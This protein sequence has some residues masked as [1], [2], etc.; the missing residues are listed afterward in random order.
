MPSLEWPKRHGWKLLVSNG[1]LRATGTAD[2][3][4][5]PAIAAPSAGGHHH[6]RW[7]WR[8]WQVAVWS[9]P[10]HGSAPRG[11]LD[12]ELTHAVAEG[13]GAQAKAGGGLIGTFDDPGTA[14][15][16]GQDVGSLCVWQAFDRM[17]DLGS[18]D[19]RSAAEG[20]VE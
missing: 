16:Y 14:F 18:S 2:R 12:T 7:W 9:E 15:E 3:A 13:A 19:R 10:A 4:L 20:L 17:L 11:A 8:T 6:I 1:M 5:Q